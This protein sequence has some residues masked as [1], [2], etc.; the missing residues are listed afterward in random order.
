MNNETY[1]T[2]LFKITE[3][4]N[5]IQLKEFK[6]L[7]EEKIKDPSTTSVFSTICLDQFYLKKYMQGIFKIISIGGFGIWWVI[8]MYS[9]LSRTRKFNVEIATNIIEKIREKKND[10]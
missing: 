5:D 2:S 10:S 9:A 4:L 8:D 7:F 1:L 3:N 6:D